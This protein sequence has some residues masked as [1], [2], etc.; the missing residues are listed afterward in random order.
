MSKRIIIGTIIYILVGWILC[1]ID[2]YERYSWYSGIWHGFFFVPSVIKSFIWHSP[3]KAQMCTTGYQ[4][5]FWL[6]SLVSILLCL[7]IKRYETEDVE[8]EDRYLHQ[9]Q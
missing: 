6:F 3:Y 7:G 5:M 9:N 2:Q 1:H 8:Q 4:I